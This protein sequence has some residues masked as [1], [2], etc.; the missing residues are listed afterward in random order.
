MK[1]SNNSNINKAMQIYKQNKTEPVKDTKKIEKPKDQLQLSTKAKEYQI[2]MNA[3]K[4]LPEVREDL[5]NKLKDE[6][7]QGKYN[8]SGKEI[9]DS[10]IEGVRVDK[11]I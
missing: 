3:F 10:I 5:V 1:I 8:V 7:N 4:K 11:K 9:V 2:A 6:I